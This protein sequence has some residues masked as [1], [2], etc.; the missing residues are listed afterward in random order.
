MRMKSVEV[1]NL[2]KALKI[3]IREA[4]IKREWTQEYLAKITGLSRFYIIKIEIGQ[5]ANPGIENIK[6]LCYALGLKIEEL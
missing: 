6:K 5:I 3:K 1:K 2:K 4:R